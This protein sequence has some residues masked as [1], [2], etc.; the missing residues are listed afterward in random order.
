MSIERIFFK[1]ENFVLTLIYGKLTEAE[2]LEHVQAM[3]H[4]YSDIYGIKE[5]ADCRFLYDVSELSGSDLLSTANLEKGSARAIG[6]KGA[7]VASS[8]VVFGLA[9]MYAAIASNI[10]EDSKAFRDMDE[11]F[12]FLELGEV[13]KKILPLI[14]ETAYNTRLNVQE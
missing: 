7:I 5:L 10:R 9:S 13:K 6:G 4:Q 11:A 12:E 1:K 2:L 3:N 8:D 14:S